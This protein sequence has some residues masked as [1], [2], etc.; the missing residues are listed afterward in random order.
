MTRGALSL[1]LLL[2]LSAC[3]FK[4]MYGQRA[5]APAVTQELARVDIAPM[6]DRLGQ[7]VRGAISDRITPTG[8]PS[9]PLYSL[10]VSVI[11][12]REDVGIRGDASITRANYR[13]SA[14]FDLIDLESDDVLITGTTWSQTAFDVVQQDF[15]TVTAELDAQRRLADEIAEE[16]TTRLAVYFDREK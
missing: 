14:Q 13:L 3:G 6:E 2:A 11:E 10:K 12:E 15:A 7:L 8:A 4:P 5:E 1:V 9:N 16:I